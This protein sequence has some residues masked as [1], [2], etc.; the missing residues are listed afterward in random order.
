MR[1]FP[2]FALATALFLP[3]WLPAPAAAD[4]VVRVV[5]TN[6]TKP[7]GTLLAGAYSSPD[8][9]LGATTVASRDVPVAGNVR[10]GTVAFDMPLP[11]GTYA[12]SVLQDMNGNRRLDTNFIGIPTEASGSSNDAPAKWSAP[13]FK[14]AV[15]TVGDQPIELTIRLN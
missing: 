7:G 2:F 3:V 14:D 11:P 5:V 8:T 13:K 1:H 6:I 15:F 9:W 4:T 10:N 12:L